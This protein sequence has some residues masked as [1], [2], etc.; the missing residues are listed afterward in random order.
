M[1]SHPSLSYGKPVGRPSGRTR[2]PA[3]LNLS[4]ELINRLADYCAKCGRSKS[5]VANTAI[6]DYLDTAYNDN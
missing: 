3:N 1:K 5:E 4:I 2:R 6:S